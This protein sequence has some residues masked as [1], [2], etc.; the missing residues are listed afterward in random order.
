[1]NCCDICGK[2]IYDSCHPPKDTLLQNSIVFLCY[3]CMS[4]LYEIRENVHQRVLTLRD[5]PLKRVFNDLRN[6]SGF[7]G[8]SHTSCTICGAILKGQDE[9]VLWV[10]KSTYTALYKVCLNCNAILSKLLEG[11]K[12][13]DRELYE[14]AYRN[15]MVIGIR[16]FLRGRGWK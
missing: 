12:R 7:K 5:A 6:K 14:K 2:H 10:Y 4:S 13:I 16:L 3:S 9:G 8:K 15:M 11:A 1:M